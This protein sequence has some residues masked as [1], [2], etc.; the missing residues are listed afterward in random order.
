[1]KYALGPPSRER[2]V[3][4]ISLVNASV[5]LTWIIPVGHKR[6]LVQ[7]DVACEGKGAEKKEKRYDQTLPD[8]MHFSSRQLVTLFLKPQFSVC[9]LVPLFSVHTLIHT[10]TS[11]VCVGNDHALTRELTE[12]LTR[13]SGPRLRPSKRPG[14]QETTA[15]IVCSSSFSHVALVHSL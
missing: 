8:D 10:T 6:Q 9:C 5:A 15:T 12:R 13:T 3:V 7:T 1:M 4:S 2:P 11:Y 14:E